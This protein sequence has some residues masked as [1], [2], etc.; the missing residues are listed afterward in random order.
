MLGF[1]V[2]YTR[3]APL[4]AFLSYHQSQLMIQQ[5][6]PADRHTGPLEFPYGRGINFQIDTLDAK[7]LC[8]SLQSHGFPLRKGLEDHWRRI[9]GG[10]LAGSLEFQVLDP[11]GYYFRFA[12]D[13]GEKPSASA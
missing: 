9:A 11:D 13:L 4:F 5:R 6:E 2:E 1:K 8:E 3:E 12:Q 7:E 10:A